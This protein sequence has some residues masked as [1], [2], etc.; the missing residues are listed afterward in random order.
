MAQILQD[1]LM[2]SFVRGLISRAYSPALFL[3]RH[4][5]FGI[6]GRNVEQVPGLVYNYDIFD[7]VRTVSNARAPSASAGTVAPNTVGK[8]TVALATFREKLALEYGQ[9]I[10]IRQLGRNADD[11]DMM[12]AKYIERQV[13]YLRQRA[14]NLREFVTGALFQGGKYGFFLNGDD[15]VPT[16]DTGNATVTVDLKLDSG[17]VLTGGSF[18]AGLQMGTGSNIIDAAWSSTSTDIPAHLDKIGSALQDLVGAPLA[19]VYCGTDVWANVIN[20]DKVRQIAGT[21]NISADFTQE[22]DKGPDGQLTGFVKSTLKARPWVTFY[23]WDGSLKVAATNAS[24]FTNVKLLPRNY[25]T[26]MVDP[27]ASPWLRMVEGSDYIADNDW[28]DPVER[29]GFYAWAQQ[30][31]DLARVWYHTF[32]AVGLELNM[33]KGIGYARVQ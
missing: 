12:G 22:P 29:F 3:S 25:I 9:L 31:S 24:T 15:W 7:N 32:Q 21:S 20:N 13:K 18:A 8:N 33:P 16:Y 30:K 11:R 26:F 1:V 14:D 4:L 19:R 17:N 6:D 10:N 27:E 2:A 5:G 28:T 23:V